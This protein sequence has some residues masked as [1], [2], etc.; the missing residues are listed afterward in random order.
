[1]ALLGLFTRLSMGLAALSLFFV[2]GFFYN[3]SGAVYH[4]GHM[5]VMT[6]LILSLSRCG[7][8]LSLDRVLGKKEAPRRPSWHYGWPLQLI[9]VWVVLVFVT[10][11]YQKLAYGDGLNW[12]LSDN[13]ALRIFSSPMITPF[14]QMMLDYPSWVLRSL[15][16]GAL[17]I[18]VLA[19]LALLGK[20]WWI[21]FSFSWYLLHL[22]VTA[23]L[24]GHNGFF[25]QA[26]C[27]AA[28]MPFSWAWQRLR[29]LIPWREQIKASGSPADEAVK[30]ALMRS[31]D[32]ANNNVAIDRWGDFRPCC[33][34]K[35]G[36]EGYPIPN[37]RSDTFKTAFEHPTFQRVRK[38]LN[39]GHFP[40]PCSVCR[41]EEGRGLKSIKNNLT[42]MG[43]DLSGRGVETLEIFVGSRCNMKCRMCDEHASSKWAKELGVPEERSNQESI[44]KMLEEIDFHQLKYVRF[45][46]GETLL[47]ETFIKVLE[48]FIEKGVAKK[49]HI[50]LMTN[51]SIPPSERLIRLFREFKIVNLDISLDGIG[52]CGEYIRHG[53]KWSKVEG[54]VQKWL[55]DWC[56][57]GVHTTLQAANYAAIDQ[58]ILFCMDHSIKFWGFRALDYPPELKLERLPQGLRQE[59]AD[60]LK[61]HPRAEEMK[62]YL[63]RHS[64]PGAWTYL[65]EKVPQM[66]ALEFNEFTSYL[67]KYDRRWNVSWL[68]SLPELKALVS[69]YPETSQTQMMS[70]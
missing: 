21:A 64:K 10:S 52:S 34:F 51:G 22:G 61:T 16:F 15:A 19:P 47:N 65:V 41:R 8:T 63:K 42:D 29:L 66:E 23:T 39:Q 68:S 27:Y 38:E 62:A 5:I 48:I 56:S 69:K 9:K 30:K 18:E 60:R 55:N 32:Y 28:V 6:V 70:R 36:V 3:F 1:M 59:V 14:G 49:I 33:R 45:L 57:V 24:G 31:C 58:M 54:A 50:Q 12:A 4:H 2:I 7:E 46:G 17:M 44:L 35:K 40:K 20:Y 67:E 53:V 13:L 11:G 37:D 43:I 26:F 25:V